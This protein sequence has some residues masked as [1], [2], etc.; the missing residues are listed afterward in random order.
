MGIGARLAVAA[1]LGSALVTASQMPVKVY[2][3]ADGLASN[4]VNKIVQDS[5]GY[6]WFCT[7]DGLSRFDGYSFTSYGPQHGLPVGSVNDLLEMQTGEYWVATSVG[8]VRFDP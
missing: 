6:L 8:L 5:H 3:T 4:R 7:Q 1:A 2:T